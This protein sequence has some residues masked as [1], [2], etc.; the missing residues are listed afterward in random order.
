MGETTAE[1]SHTSVKISEPA[2]KPEQPKDLDAVKAIVASGGDLSQSTLIKNVIALYVQDRYTSTH[3]VFSDLIFTQLIN[4]FRADYRTNIANRCNDDMSSTISKVICDVADRVNHGVPV[5]APVVYDF[6][7][8]ATIGLALG[9]E[10]QRTQSAA[11]RHVLG[12]SSFNLLFS[13]FVC[14]L[15][16]LL[17][18]LFVGSGASAS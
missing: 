15:V 3:L 14:L 5:P 17:T 12:I 8:H 4:S 18:C 9:S 1:L 6:P 2:W 11:T 16:C 10:R 13:C 7:R